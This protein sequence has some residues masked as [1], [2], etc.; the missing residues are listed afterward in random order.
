MLVLEAHEEWGMFVATLN[1][2]VPVVGVVMMMLM[3]FLMMLMLS[4]I[5]MLM[6]MTVPRKQRVHKQL[7]HLT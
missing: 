5:L 4:L 7:W 2:P 1:K 3:L 6:V